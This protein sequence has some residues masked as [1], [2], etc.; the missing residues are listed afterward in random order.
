[1][2]TDTHCHLADPAFRDDLPDVL[3]TARH[4]CVSGII[5]P[6]AAPNDWQTV[7]D[8][9]K[10]PMIRAAA[11]GIHPWYLHT[12]YAGCF[13]DLAHLL[14]QYPRAWV[15]EIGLDFHEKS[16]FAAQ[17]EQ[18][19][20]CFETQ[21]DL[22]QQFRRPVILHSLKATDAIVQSLRRT[23]FAQ[24]GIA[25][26]FSGSPE[27]AQRL[28]RHGFLIGLGNLLLQPTA[29]KV[30]RLAGSLHIHHIVLETDSPFGLKAQ[31]NT[32][33]NLLPIAQEVARIRQIP[34]PELA[35]ACEQ[36]L[37]R[38]LHHG[39]SGVNPP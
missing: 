25:H 38:L 27:E 29:K 7:L 20:Q 24:G 16:P 28:I 9:Q 32:P 34:L 31:R 26:A 6:S 15:G 39:E 36:N 21:L 1:M 13:D 10:Q 19:I 14:A 23:G 11:V 5:V 8:G 12:Q 2:F 3:Q 33:A 35:L 22:A 18:Q 17:R 4:A 30:R 37:Q